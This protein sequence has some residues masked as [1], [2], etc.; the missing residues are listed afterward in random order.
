[1]KMRGFRIE[2]E[3]IEAVLA[4]HPAVAEAVASVYSDRR[5]DK[6]LAAYV[7]AAKR[8]VEQEGPS[9]RDSARPAAESISSAAL[10]D[11]LKGKLPEYMLPSI[12]VQLEAL[13]L[14]PNGKLDRQALPAPRRSRPG[15]AGPLAAPRDRLEFQLVQLWE[16]TLGIRPIGVQDDFFELGGHS[17]LAVHLMARIEKSFGKRVPLNALFQAATVEHLAKS[18]RRQQ[19]A[20]AASALVELQAGSRRPL[21][22]VHPAG[23]GVFG[24]LDLARHLGP[25]Q[26]FYGLQAP[27][28]EGEERPGGSIEE[29]A[30]RYLEAVAEV[31]PQG[32][33]LLGGHSFGGVVAFEMAR[34]LLEA[35]QS[36]D[37]LAL[38]DSTPPEAGKQSKAVG[39]S[40]ALAGFALHVGLSL[41]QLPWDRLASLQGEEK[42]SL[43]LE[44]AREAGAVPSDL[45]LAHFCRLF[46]IFKAHVQAHQGYRPRPIPVRAMLFRAKESIQ[47]GPRRRRP[48]VLSKAV[49]WLGKQ[50]SDPK[51][52]WSRLAA[53]GVEV[54]EMPGNHFTMLRQPHVKSLAERLNACL[55]GVQDKRKE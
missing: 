38:F 2:L 27:E 12:F 47:G 15:E 36:V 35:G 23:G 32:P 37:L 28:L 4:Q 25:D 11:F 16:K 18:L 42:M 19:E 55:A 45:G 54:Y 34:Q 43:V 51:A 52:D 33:Y 48:A 26:P 10:R 31:Q 24:Y 30:A 22:C 14:T 40:T 53:K 44:Q 49:R 5:G 20:A 7:T 50:F 46:E 1:V 9:K 29:L 39:D 41:R 8:E 17:L 13:P 21:F 3:E 6:L